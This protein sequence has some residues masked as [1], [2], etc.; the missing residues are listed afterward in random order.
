M[1]K[2]IYYFIILSLFFGTQQGAK[3]SDNMMANVDDKNKF[4]QT[5]IP[6]VF[7]IGN[8]SFVQKAVTVAND[9]YSVSCISS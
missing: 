3:N 9:W 4:S 8:A 2:K 7:N 1:L 5:E 6:S